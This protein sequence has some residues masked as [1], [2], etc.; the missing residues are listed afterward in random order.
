MAS[1]DTSVCALHTLANGHLRWSLVH[2]SYLPGVTASEI[3]EY[4]YCSHA[5]YLKQ[6]DVPVSEEARRKMQAGVDWQQ[7]ADAVIPEAITR[8][9]QSKKAAQ[10][11]WVA[12]I[13]FLISVAVWESFSLLH[14]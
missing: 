7:Q 3:A 2:E 6:R 4:V 13:A 10:I 1:A 8:H 12:L 9:Q 5:W 14:R 11:A